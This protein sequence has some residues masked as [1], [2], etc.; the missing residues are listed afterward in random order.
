MCRLMVRS[1]STNLVIEYYLRM[2]ERYKEE[3]KKLRPA[4]EWASCNLLHSSNIF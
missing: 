4:R 3:K 1:E 2:S